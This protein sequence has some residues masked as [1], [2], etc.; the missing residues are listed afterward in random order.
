MSRRR[1]IHD[2]DARTTLV[3]ELEIASGDQRRAER[4]EIF[5][6]DPVQH[7]P[8]AFFRLFLIA[9]HVYEAAGRWTLDRRHLAERGR[10]DARD[11]LEPPKE[12]AVQPR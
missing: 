6:R 3:L 9:F 5:R 10:A 7:H 2:R 11:R 1:S 12:L 4:R 8:A